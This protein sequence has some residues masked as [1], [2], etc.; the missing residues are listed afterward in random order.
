MRRKKTY[1]FQ[2]QGVKHMQPRGAEAEDA[3]MGT[4]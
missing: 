4:A 1:K 3:H 2:H